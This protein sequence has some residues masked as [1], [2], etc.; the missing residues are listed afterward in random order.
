MKCLMY[1]AGHRISARLPDPGIMG[2]SAVQEARK[3]AVRPL[4]LYAYIAAWYKMEQKALDALIR[5][6]KYCSDESVASEIEN[7]FL[8]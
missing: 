4:I 7:N 2:K 6:E 8:Y 1:Y 5:A 3:N